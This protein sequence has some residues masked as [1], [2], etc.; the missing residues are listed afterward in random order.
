MRDH[1]FN[2]AD[3]QGKKTQRGDPVSDADEGRVPRSDRCGW[4]GRGSTWDANRVAH[5]GMVP[6]GAHN[7][8]TGR[9]RGASLVR[10]SPL[11]R[12]NADGSGA[13]PVTQETVSVNP[14]QQT[15]R[16]P[17]KMAAKTSE[18]FFWTAFFLSTRYRFCLAS[19][20]A[21]AFLAVGSPVSDPCCW[22]DPRNTL[23]ASSSS[24]NKNP[25]LA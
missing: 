3:Q 2:S 18:A 15:H 6:C 13:A 22:S 25:P 24:Q 21:A 17:A 14:L 11:W 16:W 9:K 12:I 19:A 1:N 5:A 7:A 4:N 20:F 23:T 8:H 10:S